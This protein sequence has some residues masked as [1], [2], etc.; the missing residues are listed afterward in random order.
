M[1]KVTCQ[2]GSAFSAKD[3][4][5]GK[6][7]KCPK[8]GTILS[9]PAPQLEEV[10]PLAGSPAS[11]SLGAPNSDPLGIGSA[12]DDVF[13]NV[14]ALPAASSPLQ[15]MPAPTMSMPPAQVPQDSHSRVKHTSSISGWDVA[16]GIVCMIHGLLVV[17]F[18]GT[19]LLGL[20]GMTGE[21]MADGFGFFFVI[22]LLITLVAFGVG[23]AILAAGLGLLLQQPWSLEVGVPASYVHF[24]FLAIGAVFM[25]INLMQAATI[26]VRLAVMGLFGYLFATVLLSIAPA[27]LLKLNDQDEHY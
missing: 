13:G 7:V 11:D 1:I 16:T 5:G 19:S 9:I 18:L 21:M 3:S 12:G 2:C 6:K 26:S 17:G 25:I 4:L 27:L 15:T 23:V 22:S 20:I 14:A 10:D 24:A 8:C